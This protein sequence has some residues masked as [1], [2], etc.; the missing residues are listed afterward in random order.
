MISIACGKYPKMI[1]TDLDNVLKPGQ[2]WE[3]KTSLRTYRPVRIFRFFQTEK[4]DYS[5]EETII[6]DGETILIVEISKIPYYF[7][8]DNKIFFGEYND[9][10]ELTVK[11]NRYTKM[12][13][14]QK[15]WIYDG[16]LFEPKDM[17][18]N[19][20]LICDV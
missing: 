6:R 7:D 17:Y 18:E 10:L 11:M 3:V 5:F 20:S 9:D 2:V 14:R 15:T 12:L 16:H 13:T 8:K 4:S 19:F 1:T